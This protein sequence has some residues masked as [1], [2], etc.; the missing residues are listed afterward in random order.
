MLMD[1]K[2]VRTE[3]GN[4]SASLVSVPMVSLT[5]K[6]SKEEQSMPLPHFEELTLEEFDK[7]LEASNE[8]L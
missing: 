6:I 3:T 2:S 8:R 1:D 7:R 5:S 4:I